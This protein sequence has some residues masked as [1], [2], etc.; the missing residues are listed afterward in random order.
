MSATSSSVGSGAAGAASFVG[1]DSRRYNY[2]EPK[3]KRATHYEDVTVDVQ[4][5]PE[6]YLI[7][8]WIMLD[9][10]F[11]CDTE[12]GGECLDRGA[13]AEALSRR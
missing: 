12:V 3:G 7:Q 8:N 2:F 6:R 1:S 4:P 11:K 10:R 9:S 13:V 5:D